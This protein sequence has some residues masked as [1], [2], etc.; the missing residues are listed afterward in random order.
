MIKTAVI[1]TVFNRRE[2][3]L[4]GLR[5]LYRAFEELQNEQPYESY[6]FD[7]YMTD[8]GCSDGTADAVKGEFPDVHIIQGDGNLYW[9]GGMR[10]AWQTAI[11]SSEKYDFYLWF[12]DDAELYENALVI[13]FDSHSYS[14][15]KSIISGAFCDSKGNASYGGRDRKSNIL[16]PHNV[17]RPIFLMNGNLVLIPNT[18]VESVG[19]IDKVFTH[20]FGDW[21]Y[22]CR[23]LENGF[24]VFLSAEYVG[25]TERHDN[26]IEPFL[27]PKYSLGKRMSL[28][29]SNKHS[30]IKSFIFCKRHFGIVKALRVIVMQNIYAICPQ[31]YNIRRCI[32]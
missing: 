23:V 30:A 6:H 27:D 16:T 9:S 1:L 11:H 13:M 28:L 25:K 12:N 5:T 15:K 8:D 22:G 10:K 2:V 26:D 20:S 18:I 29:Y 3:T 31:L 19:I 24:G 4:K 32:K 7:I 21:D 17:L 14:D